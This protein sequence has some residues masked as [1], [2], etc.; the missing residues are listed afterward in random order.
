MNSGERAKTEEHRIAIEREKQEL[1]KERR[2]LDAMI[3]AQRKGKVG[4]ARR[5]KKGKKG[6]VK[7][8]LGARISGFQGDTVTDQATDLDLAEIKNYQTNPH[9]KNNTGVAKKGA[10]QRR[11]SSRELM[12]SDAEQNFVV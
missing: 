2:K 10:K 12:A 8:V 3:V 4:K 1:G 7:K 5:G 11:M 6:K 9:K